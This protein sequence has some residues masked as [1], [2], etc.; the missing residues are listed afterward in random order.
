MYDKHFVS[1]Q[2]IALGFGNEYAVVGSLNFALLTM[3]SDFWTKIF[4]KYV[5]SEWPNLE[6]QN[7]QLKMTNVEI[8]AIQ[9]NFFWQKMEFLWTNIGFSPKKS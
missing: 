3:K 9:I 1:P 2:S 7:Y 6:D 4:P 5:L 8:L